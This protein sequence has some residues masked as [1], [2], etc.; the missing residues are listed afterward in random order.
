MTMTRIRPPRKPSIH[1]PPSPTRVTVPSPRRANNAAHRGGGEWCPR[2][3]QRP[4][5]RHGTSVEGGKVEV[6]LPRE[7][8]S[9]N[10]QRKVREAIYLSPAGTKTKTRDCQQMQAKEWDP[11]FPQ[12]WTQQQ[13][14]KGGG[15]TSKGGERQPTNDTT[16]FFHGDAS[17]FSPT[18]DAA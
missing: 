18:H 1:L 5:Q 6:G 4:R 13:N 7:A 8:E 3:H 11:S 14:E 15:A 10:R 9:A 16:I 12:N 2:S 17:I